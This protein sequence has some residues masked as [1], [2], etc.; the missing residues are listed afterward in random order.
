MQRF[1]QWNLTLKILLLVFLLGLLAAGIALYTLSQLRTIDREYR[2]VLDKDAQAAV[3]V[4][5]AL[6]D[7]SEASRRVYGVLVEQE[8]AVMLAAKPKLSQLETD[9]LHK[10]D[11]LRELIPSARFQLDKIGEQETEFFQHAASIVDAAAKWR[12]DR[13]LEIIDNQ[14]HPLLNQLRHAME[15]VCEDTV[16]NF[17]QSADRLA[18]TAEETQRNTILWAGLILIITLGLAVRWSMTSIARPIDRLAEEKDQA[19][20]LMRAKSAFLATMSHEIRTPMNGVL[21]ILQLLS[22]TPLDAKQ[23]DYVEKARGAGEL[24]LDLLNEVLDFSKIEAEKLTIELAPFRVDELMQKLHNVLSSVAKNKPIA[25]SC[26]LDPAVPRALL[27]DALRVQQVLLNLA[28]NAVKFTEQGEVAVSIRLLEAN[29]DQAHLAFA[30]KDTGIGIAPERHNSIFEAFTQADDSMSR[31]F[32][33]T[34]LGLSISQRLVELMGGELHVES[35]LARLGG[36]IALYQMIAHS[37]FQDYE[38]MVSQAMEALD[39]GERETTLRIVHTLKG[40]AGSLGAE[41]LQTMA[42]ELEIQI[43]NGDAAEILSA[44]LA[45]LNARLTQDRITVKQIADRGFE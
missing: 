33:G 42:A 22:H 38:H 27:G 16:H 44:P 4:G 13:A 11:T 7:L 37:F 45:A 43:Q 8:S 29:T 6:L 40:V 24:L 41:T 20:K 3:L 26:Q 23:L 25:I 34:G 21:G 12:G 19:E 17:Q 15:T 31:R 2:A 10:L 36:D 1:R 30:V 9:F 39:K 32:G 5:A 28:G 18:A 14:F 35:A